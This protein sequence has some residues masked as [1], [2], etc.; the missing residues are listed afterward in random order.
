[1]SCFPFDLINIG[2]TEPRT[3]GKPE[4]HPRV[5]KKHAGGEPTELEWVRNVSH[6]VRRSHAQFSTLELHNIFLYFIRRLEK[7][8]FLV[9]RSCTETRSDSLPSLRL[10]QALHLCMTLKI[11]KLLN[12]AF[13]FLFV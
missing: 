9:L 13:L 7:L 10:Q 5:K 6:Q 12:S 3:D 1:M 8:V 2:A 4:S 11:F